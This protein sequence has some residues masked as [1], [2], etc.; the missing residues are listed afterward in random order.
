MG[1]A[2]VPEHDTY[3]A[4]VIAEATLACPAVGDLHAGGPSAI[5]TYLPGRRVNGV[6]IEDDR[7]LVAV[8]LVHGVPVPTLEKQ[9]RAALAPHVAERSVDVYVADVQRA[10]DVPSTEGRG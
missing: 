5:A 8:V 6:R 10:E 9:V 7:V 4:D 3:D 2:R 1:Y